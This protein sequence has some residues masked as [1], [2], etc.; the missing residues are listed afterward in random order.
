MEIK[1]KRKYIG[2]VLKGGGISIKLEDSLSPAIMQLAY[3]RFGKEYFTTT[4]NAKT[5][6]KQDT[7]DSSNPN[8]EDND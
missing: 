6:K 8:G 3:N 7:E 2:K 1:I 4:S 5:R